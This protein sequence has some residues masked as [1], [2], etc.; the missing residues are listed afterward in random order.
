MPQATARPPDL[1][2]QGQPVGTRPPDL[3]ASGQPAATS[4]PSPQQQSNVGGIA[5]AAGQAALP[6]IASWTADFA[7]NPDAWRT[8]KVIGEL[9]GGAA[10]LSHGGLFGAAGGS[11]MGAKAGWRLSNLAQR[12]AQAVSNTVRPAAQAVLNAERYISPLTIAQSGLDL[13]QMADPTR[14][15][16]GFLGIGAG[17]EKIDPKNVP[18]INELI[19]KA[20]DAIGKHDVAD[21][22]RGLEANAVYRKVK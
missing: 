20:A 12:G 22:W 6:K 8:A 10:G 13:A 3:D 14:K 16:I 19:A 18:L 17:D 7:A 21:L 1:D 5:L 11:Y 15:D 9:A 2:A 4:A